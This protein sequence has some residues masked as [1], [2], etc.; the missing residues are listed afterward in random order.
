VRLHDANAS[1]AEASP[2][3]PEAAETNQLA[4]EAD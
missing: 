3:K 4:L 2:E 1:A